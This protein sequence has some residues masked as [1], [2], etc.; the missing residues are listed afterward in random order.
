[1]YNVCEDEPLT[2]RDHID[3]VASLVG[4]T[5][6]RRTMHRARRLGGSKTELLARSQRVSN[7]SFRDATGWEPSY[8]S[9]REGFPA[10]FADLGR[11][12]A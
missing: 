2:R 8:P 11:A 12:A 10:V 9:I 5:S 1:V 4:R 3:V 6:L 7:R